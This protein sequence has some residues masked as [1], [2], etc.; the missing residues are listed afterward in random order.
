MVA[1]SPVPLT[2]HGI[3]TG[4]WLSMWW[5]QGGVPILGDGGIDDFPTEQ[6]PP[7]AGRLAGDRPLDILQRDGHH[8]AVTAIARH[9]PAPCEKGSDP[10]PKGLG[11]SSE[12]RKRWAWMV[13]RG[14]L[15]RRWPSPT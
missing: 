8:K 1:T 2:Q 5:F 11:E 3:K 12:Q 6:T 14:C 7:G 13:L 4:R 10:T 15:P 9:G